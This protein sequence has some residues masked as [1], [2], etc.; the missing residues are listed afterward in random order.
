[1]R[2]PCGPSLKILLRE[3]RT[4]LHLLSSISPTPAE[5]RLPSRILQER[6]PAVLWGWL[7]CR[8]DTTISHTPSKEWLSSSRAL[9]FKIWP[10]SFSH[11]GDR[12]CE[13]CA[14]TKLFP[15]GGC[16]CTRSK[17]C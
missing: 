17:L 14:S 6:P 4:H 1:M 13:N 15:S 12:L 2:G 9:P 10:L 7:I 11:S 8:V 16:R 3:P 5:T